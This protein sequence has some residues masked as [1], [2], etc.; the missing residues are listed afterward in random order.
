M[1]TDIH[2]A[3]KREEGWICVPPKARG[4]RRKSILDSSRFSAFR[5]RKW[6]LPTRAISEFLNAI[7]DWIRSGTP[8][9]LVYAHSR[10][11][12]SSAIEYL[13]DVI[14]PLLGLDWPI[15]SV[16]TA[17][18]RGERHTEYLE[19]FLEDI[20]FVSPANGRKSEK[21]RAILN[22]VEAACIHRDTDDFI[23]FVDDVQWMT[24]RKWG[25]LLDLYN[26]WEKRG[27]K[28]LVILVGQ[29][30]VKDKPGLLKGTNQWPVL[31]RFMQEVYPFRSVQSGNDLKRFLRAYD[32]DSAEKDPEGR[33][34]TEAALPRAFRNGL[35]LE[36][37]SDEVW[38]GLVDAREERLEGMPL[39]SFPMPVVSSGLLGTL[40]QVSELDRPTF[41]PD[42]T[43]FKRGFLTRG[44]GLLAVDYSKS[45]EDC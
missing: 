36:S 29:E 32:D 12:K 22:T 6:L 24:E 33:P 15:F 1:R 23:L 14:N 2:Q 25:Y 27:L 10:F 5:Y 45:L 26:Q 19:N 28:P 7:A 41:R 44:G 20:S 30:E 16:T 11:G 38:H 21:R 43:H 17:D 37:L 3:N 42:R 13:T 40:S 39:K 8:G 31:G 18:G 9:A 35:R 34:I 4:R